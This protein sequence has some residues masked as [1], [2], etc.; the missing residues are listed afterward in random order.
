MGIRTRCAERHPGDRLIISA[1][2]LYHTAQSVASKT[3]L[4]SGWV[5]CVGV[6][7]VRAADDVRFPSKATEILRC[8]E[9]SQRA[10]SRQEQRGKPTGFVLDTD[11]TKPRV[12]F[13][14]PLRG[15]P[16]NAGSIPLRQQ[17]DNREAI[18]GDAVRSALPC[19]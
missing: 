6:H 1:Q 15:L 13:R 17:K 2:Q 4:M 11:P 19:A 8:R 18:S 16:S 5:N 7:Q 14:A 3:R 10:I 12:Y 9:M